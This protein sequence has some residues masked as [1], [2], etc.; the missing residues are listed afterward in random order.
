MRETR[1]NRSGDGGN[2]RD[3]NMDKR[4]DEVSFVFLSVECLGIAFVSEEVFIDM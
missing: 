3:E 2:W 1:E 4:K